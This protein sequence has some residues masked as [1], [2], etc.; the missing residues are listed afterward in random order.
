MRSPMKALTKKQ[1][2]II[3]DFLSDK[4]M[5]YLFGSAYRGELRADSDID[6]AFY[7]NEKQDIFSNFENAN[8]LADLL[9]RN[10]DLIDLKQASTVFAFQVL[11]TSKCLFVKEKNLKEEFEYL[12]YSSYA[13][14]NEERA[15]ILKSYGVSLW[16]M[17]HRTVEEQAELVVEEL[18]NE[19]LKKDRRS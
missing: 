1:E 12:T 15:E 8:K 7:T 5:V 14:L 16:L 18:V 10:V 4:E 11:T 6:I 3:I 9:G 2:K 13:R 17:I 19:Q